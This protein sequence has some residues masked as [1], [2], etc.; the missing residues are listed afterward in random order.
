MIDNLKE[1]YKTIL[2]KDIVK[3]YSLFG[4]P[5]FQ[6]GLVW[7][8]EKKAKFI[9]SLYNHYPI[10]MFVLWKIDSKLDLMNIGIGLKNKKKYKYLIIDGQQRIRTLYEVFNE[11]SENKDNN[12]T[13]A[14]F[15]VREVKI[16]YLR[17]PKHYKDNS[18]YK[19]NWFPIKILI[20][21]YKEKD[22]KLLEEYVFDV[23]KKSI[24]EYGE[25][26]HNILN[27]E[28]PSYVFPSNSEEAEVIKA[29]NA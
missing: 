5:D 10:G 21:Y 2:I 12:L 20:R 17:D 3:S 18:R 24:S 29:Y 15:N 22:E 4:I 23:D 14:C 1:G 19:K 6:R 26:F 28:I 8:N 7:D 11:N 27:Q 25:K 16:H 9:F 13:L